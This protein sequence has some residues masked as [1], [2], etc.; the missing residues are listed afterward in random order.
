[1]LAAMS[2]CLVLRLFGV[3]VEWWL[4]AHGVLPPLGV[5]FCTSALNAACTCRTPPGEGGGS[6]AQGEGSPHRSEA[7]GGAGKD[8]AQRVCTSE[9]RKIGEYPCAARSGQSPLAQW[10]C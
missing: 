4:A 9:A 7:T 6:K 8:G 2:S 5:G 1:M 3:A 10:I